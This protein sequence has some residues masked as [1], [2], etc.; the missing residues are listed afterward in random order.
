[1]LLDSVDRAVDR[2]AVDAL[3]HVADLDLLQVAGLDL[4]PGGNLGDEHAGE[5]GVQGEAETHPHH[6]RLR[7]R[8]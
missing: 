6:G 2:P 1:M 8:L 4:T 5:G 7:L 3:E